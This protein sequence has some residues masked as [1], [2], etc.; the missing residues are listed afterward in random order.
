MND[1]L[2]VSRVLVDGSQCPFAVFRF[3]YC[4]KSEYGPHAIIYETDAE[5]WQKRCSQCYSSL[6]RLHLHLSQTVLSS[7]CPLK[8]RI[9]FSGN[10][11]YFISSLLCPQ[12]F[13]QRTQARALEPKGEMKF[14]TNHAQDAIK[15]GR[16]AKQERPVKRERDEELEELL[17]SAAQ[18]KKAKPT[19]TIDLSDD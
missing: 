3:R 8:K 4:S 14:E 16:S 5:A 9:N 18:V 10:I 13:E 19:E 2:F 1:R 15:Y 6:G 12:D 11:R 7:R 17:A